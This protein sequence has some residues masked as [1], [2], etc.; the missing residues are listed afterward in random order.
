MLCIYLNSGRPPSLVIG[1]L[2]IM[3]FSNKNTLLSL[4]LVFAFPSTTINSSW[5]GKTKWKWNPKHRQMRIKVGQNHILPFTCSEAVHSIL[6]LQI[7]YIIWR[8]WSIIMHQSQQ[9]NSIQI[10]LSKT[11]YRRCVLNRPHRLKKTSS[12]LSKRHD[13]LPKWPHREANNY[14]SLLKCY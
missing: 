11:G 1:S 5:T 12:M 3:I 4:P 10:Q 2:N 14:I 8:Y 7:S 9:W 6:I 13:P